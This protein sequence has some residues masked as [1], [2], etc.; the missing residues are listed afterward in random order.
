MRMAI[1]GTVSTNSRRTF[2][3]WLGRGNITRESI[4]ASMAP[5]L[6]YQVHLLNSHRLSA[7]WWRLMWVAHAPAC[8][9][10]SSRSLAPVWP[11]DFRRDNEKDYFLAGLW[12]RRRYGRHLS[13][14]RAKNGKG[15]RRMDEDEG[16][17]P[18]GSGTST[19]PHATGTGGGGHN[20]WHSHQRHQKCKSTRTSQQPAILLGSSAQ[21]LPSQRDSWGKMEP[22]PLLP[23]SPSSR[24]LAHTATRKH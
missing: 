17:C 18:S 8:L 9:R 2:E 19:G 24:R 5:C 21:L 11:I 10:T 20:I 23:N 15:H 12:Q 13:Q 6:S 14:G 3:R 16:L 4:Q 1:P 22:F 7:Y